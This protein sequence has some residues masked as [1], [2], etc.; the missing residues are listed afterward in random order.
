MNVTLKDL[1]AIVIT[2][3]ALVAIPLW[4]C[5]HELRRIRRDILAAGIDI[6]Q[7]LLEQLVLLRLASMV[8]K[9]PEYKSTYMG[10]E[11]ANPRA[12]VGYPAQT[13]VEGETPEEWLARQRAKMR[14]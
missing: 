7:A 5:V 6:H 1:A 9:E 8:P 2:S 4:Y 14:G 13:A 10:K 3:A 11:I 12:P